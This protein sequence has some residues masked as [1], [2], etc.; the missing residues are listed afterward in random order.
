MNAEIDRFLV[1]L[2]ERRGASRHTIAAY[3]SDLDALSEWLHEHG[4]ETWTALDRRSVRSWLAWMHGEGLAPRTVVRRLSALRSFFRFLGREGLVTE[5]PL[6]ST[7]SPKTPKSLPAVLTV[8]EVERL[9]AVPDMSTP[10]G[11]RDRAMF[12]TLYA[13][14]L[15]LSELLAMNLDS[16]DW[17]RRRAQVM[18]KGKKERIVLLGELALD[19]L[20]RYIHAG[21]PELA[22]GRVDEA[23]FLSHLGTRLSVRGF[24]VLLQGHLKQAAIERHITPHALRHSFATHMLEGGA[25]LRAVQELLGH[26]N[27]STTQIYTHVSDTYLRE[28]YAKAHRGA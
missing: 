28:V 2:E 27:V 14:G 18:G 6:L 15:R 12:E 7:I 16:V 22:A 24:H 26:A 17:T 19:A 4:I 1:D 9:L 11:L 3:R 8:E 20:E 5:S 21:R 25:D 10:Y 13:T 23:L